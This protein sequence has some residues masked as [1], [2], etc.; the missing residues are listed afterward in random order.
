[1]S[2]YGAP[3]LFVK[4]KDNKIWD[5]LLNSTQY[6]HKTQQFTIINFEWNLGLA[7]YT[8]LGQV[9]PDYCSTLI[10]R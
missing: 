9:L 5:S 2:P 7:R 4:D 8:D 6:D 10:Y 3:F 1:M